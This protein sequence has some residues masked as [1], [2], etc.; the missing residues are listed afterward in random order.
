MPAQ[1]AVDFTNL[2]ETL[3]KFDNSEDAVD[4][5]QAS[6]TFAADDAGSGDFPEAGSGSDS[7]SGAAQSSY[8]FDDAERYTVED[9]ER[10]GGG[11]GEA[12][13]SEREHK[14][15]L[16]REKSVGLLNYSI[17]AVHVLKH[18]RS[19]LPPSSHNY[20][21]KP[22]MML[23][24]DDNL[25]QGF[26]TGI[27]VLLIYTAFYT[28]Y[29]VSFPGAEPQPGSIASW[30]DFF[31]MVCFFADIALKFNLAI[32]SPFASSFITNRYVI[33]VKY[34]KGWL[35]L[36]LASAVPWDQLGAAGSSSP[37]LIRLLRLFKLLRLVRTSKL[38]RVI[39]KESAIKMSTWSL[40]KSMV[41]RVRIRVRVSLE[42]YTAGLELGLVLS[43][44]LLDLP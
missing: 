25:V 1:K 22:F 39:M 19:I 42:S 38:V 37:R 12:K 17:K 7:G 11:G 3:S 41:G 27:L 35:L 15:H 10:G 28:T 14:K 6:Y 18:P 5:A 44:T 13:L 4:A 21:H 34:M 32:Q 8:T 40:I 16:L 30:I 33:A 9:A 36:D 24:P 31:V 2:H 43:H 23:F 20:E 29:Q 26:D